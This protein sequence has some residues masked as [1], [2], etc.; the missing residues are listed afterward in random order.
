MGTLDFTI[1]SSLLAAGDTMAVFADS[2]VL[3]LIRPAW[4]VTVRVQTPRFGCVFRGR[5]QNRFAVGQRLHP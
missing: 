2:T 3:A 1:T 5:E 4:L